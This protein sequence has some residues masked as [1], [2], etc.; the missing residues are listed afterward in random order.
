[1]NTVAQIRILLLC[2]FSFLISFGYFPSVYI[3]YAIL[4]V[5]LVHLMMQKTTII[6]KSSTFLLFILILYLV[7]VDLIFGNFEFKIWEKYL[8]L[9]IFPLLFFQRLNYD[10]YFI[11]CS[12]LVG[13]LISVFINIG[14]AC[15]HSISFA[16]GEVVFDPIL[17]TTTNSFFDSSIYGGNYFFGAEFSEFLHPTYAAM[18]GAF[19]LSIMIYYWEKIRLHDSIKAFLFI[20]IFLSI[21][22]YSSKAG[23]LTLFPV[24]LL[25]VI[26]KFKDRFKIKHIL[27]IG[28]LSL[29]TLAGV[30]V[31]NPRSKILINDLVN[32]RLIT[33]NQA[34]YSNQTRL[35]TWHASWEVIKEHPFGVGMSE[36]HEVL[37]SK[38]HE[39]S[40]S[41]PLQRSYNSH[42]Q[43]LQVGVIGGWVA[44]ILFTLVIILPFRKG[45]TPVL[46]IFLIIIFINSFFEV[47]L[48]RYEG[49]IFFS[50]F[51]SMITTFNRK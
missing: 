11:L 40:Y 32:K 27:L 28:L 34:Q 25:S 13:H 14:S 24:L 6:L 7:S 5:T 19:A 30:F 47:I 16:N 38:Y 10:Q 3:I 51:Y 33:N 44:L 9:L 31:T 42:S 46:R 37:N 36:T 29:I 20:V 49:V 45:Y 22:L 2:L 23:L 12:F 50:Y 4:V 39:L 17:S 48:A 41:T 26:Y 8:P 21:Y 35:M 43:F 15:F 18:Y 1:M